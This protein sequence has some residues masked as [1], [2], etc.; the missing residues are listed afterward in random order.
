MFQLILVLFLLNFYSKI[1]NRKIAT[2]IILVILTIVISIR[3]KILI[4]YFILKMF[5]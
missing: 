3:A 4:I 1:I 5:L 2:V